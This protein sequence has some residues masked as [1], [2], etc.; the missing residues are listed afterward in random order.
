MYIE[1]TFM[2]YGHDPGRIVGVTNSQ[3]LRF[4]KMGT[5]HSHIQQSMSGLIN[6]MIDNE[7]EAM[8]KHKE[9]MTGRIVSDTTDRLKIRNKLSPCMIH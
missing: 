8:T 2:W 3:T 7:T 9:E 6:A 4:E 5:W 1:T